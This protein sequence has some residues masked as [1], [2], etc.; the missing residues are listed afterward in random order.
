MKPIGEKNT[1]KK[2][3]A[4]SLKNDQVMVILIFG[5][6]SNTTL[7]K[8]ENLPQKPQK[9]AKFDE[10]S[11]TLSLYGKKTF[12]KKIFGFRP[13]WSQG[14]FMNLKNPY[15]QKSRGPQI[16]WPKP[17]GDMKNMAQ[18]KSSR[19]YE[20]MSI[21]RSYFI[22]FFA[23]KS[24]SGFFTFLQKKLYFL[25]NMMHIMAVYDNFSKSKCF[26]FFHHHLRWVI[27][28]I[29]AQQ[30]IKIVLYSNKSLTG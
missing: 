22:K 26:P 11:Y 18:K 7:V 19:V 1:H 16:F 4:I 6:Q 5:P 23:E 10:I 12:C 25:A 27:L 2:F 20:K 30:P 8:I 9:W 3:Q 28:H 13:F 17:T 29:L 14:Y 21:F 24:K 15:G